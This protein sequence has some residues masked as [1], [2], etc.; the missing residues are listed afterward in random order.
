MYENIGSKIKGLA[1]VSG[2]ILLIAGVIAWLVIIA[3]DSPYDNLIGWL[4]LA[5][6]VLGFIG[7]W[8]LYG[9][10]LLVEDINALRCHVC[11]DEQS[12]DPIYNGN[13]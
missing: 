6:G 1:S 12:D 7:S 3:N 4:C 5:A 10:G 9:F 8:V 11:G 13:T 2:C